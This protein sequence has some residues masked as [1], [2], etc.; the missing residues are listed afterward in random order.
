MDK[1]IKILL[2]SYM[3]GGSSLLGQ[4][5][6]LHPEASYWYEPM[7]AFYNSVM[8]TAAWTVPLDVTQS[9]FGQIR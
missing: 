7:E 9:A 1:P 2:Y 4:M 5:Y 8:G 6:N 3:R